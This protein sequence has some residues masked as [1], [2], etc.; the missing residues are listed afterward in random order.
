MIHF[1]TLAL[2]AINFL[3]M[4]LAMMNRLTVPWKW[5][6]VEGVAAPVKCTSWCK[7]VDARL[8]VDGTT[9]WMVNAAQYHGRVKHIFNPLWQ[10]KV[11]MCN[12]ALAEFKE[13][14]LLFQIDADELWLPHQIEAIW[15]AFKKNPNRNCARFYCRYFFG[16]NVVVTPANTDWA[17]TGDWLRVWR[18]HPGMKF[19]AHEPPRIAHF[20]ENGFS[21]REME[22]L[23]CVFDH[24]AY[25]YE[26]QVA[27]KEQYYGYRGAV[28][29]WRALQSNTNWPTH[30][31]HW[32]K[33]VKNG[34]IATRIY[35]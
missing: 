21:P 16:Q 32:L 34:D 15:M 5:V 13:Q 6:V 1:F 25:V 12:A 20:T 4:Q 35:T 28:E 8:S 2:D 22:A 7:P 29:Q 17:N 26:K 14:G 11:E 24:Q 23:G 30:V 31:R 33:W 19:Q 3:P 10:G 9:L 27:F 18:Y